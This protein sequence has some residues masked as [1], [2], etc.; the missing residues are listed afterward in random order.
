M[1]PSSI[2]NTATA[3]K[4]A[5]RPEGVTV[6]KLAEATNLARSSA[7]EL[8]CKLEEAGELV[9]EADKPRGRNPHVFRVPEKQ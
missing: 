1:T 4:L 2:L 7:H 6:T 5:A 9:R 8:L 3:L